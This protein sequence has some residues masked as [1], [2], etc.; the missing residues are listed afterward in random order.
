M[1]TLRQKLTKMS[2]MYPELTN[3]DLAD[4]CG[5][6][7]R[8]VRRYLGPHRLRCGVET[9]KDS[10]AKILLFDIETS[11]MEVFTWSL[12]MKGYLDIDNII[13]DWSV[14]SWA[15]KWLFDSKVMSAA[16]WPEEAQERKDASIIEGMWHLLNEADIVVAHNGAKFDVRKINARFIANGLN[17]PMPYRVIDTMK[18]AKK[19]FAMSSYKLDYL[20]GFLKLPKKIHTEFNLWKRCVAGEAKAIK[21][22]VTYNKQDVVALEELYLHLRPWIKS[23]PNVALYQDSDK[24]LCA[25]CG[26]SNLSWGGHY[27]TPMGKYS[28]YRCV[29]CGAVGRSRLSAL[30]T[31]QRKILNVSV[32]S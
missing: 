16:V 32:A 19:N 9:S 8:S 30:T 1:M 6:S 5:C 12:Y 17:P 18:V 2:K 23:H 25:N 10:P 4:A 26:N 3:R 22:M 13:K 7:R 21:E 28:A 24:T 27:Y 20:N 31:E 14:L 29:S 11:P 15:A